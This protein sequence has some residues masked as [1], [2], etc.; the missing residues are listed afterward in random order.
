MTNIL[1]IQMFEMNPYVWRLIE[2]KVRKDVSL[3]RSRMQTPLSREQKE[4]CGKTCYPMTWTLLSS[5]DEQEQN[6]LELHQA[7]Q[8][9]EPA[10]RK[11]MTFMCED[12]EIVSEKI[13]LK[14]TLQTGWCLQT[15]RELRLCCPHTPQ[16]L[17]STHH[18]TLSS[19]D[20]TRPPL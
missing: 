15:L 9:S 13:V 17:S 12:E 14:Y 1:M 2:C 8:K 16:L 4:C 5:H 20:D 19:L 11:H 6:H 3:E 7:P 18:L 10:D